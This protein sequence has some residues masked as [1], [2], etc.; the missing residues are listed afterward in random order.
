MKDVKLTLAPWVLKRFEPQLGS[1]YF[2]NAKSKKMWTGDHTIGSII[3]V[4]DGT[5]TCNQVLDILIAN[6]RSISKDELQKFL[7]AIFEMLIKE[8]YLVKS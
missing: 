6:N 7:F 5:L 1:Y 8:D 3:S 2:F 4:L